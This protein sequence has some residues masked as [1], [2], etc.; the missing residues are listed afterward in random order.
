MKLI[1]KD[2]VLAEIRKLHD[3]HISPNYVDEAGVVLEKLEDA[4]CLLEVKEVDLEKA[5]D[6]YIYTHDGR[7]RMALELDWKCC[8]LTLKGGD[9]IIKFA[10]HFF[11]LGLKV[12][13]N[14]PVSEDLEE[15]IGK[16]CSNP[17][18]FITYI[19]VGFKQ[20]FVEKDDIPL[21]IKAIKFGANWQKHKD[22]SYTKSMYKVG[23]NTGKELMKQKL[24]KEAVKVNISNSSIVSLPVN[25]NLKVGDKVLIIKED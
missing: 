10:K 21:I 1:D 14:E 3:K 19:D 18:N 13:K 9:E 2:A 20:S 22:E 4:I 12:Q 5:I 24:M 6:D 8:N 7:K 16:Y 17:E 15:E 11:E 23:V 25:C